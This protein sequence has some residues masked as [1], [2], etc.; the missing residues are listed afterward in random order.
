MTKSF[1]FLARQPRTEIAKFCSEER[2]D[3]G[4]ARLMPLLHLFDKFIVS[5]QVTFFLL[6]ALVTSC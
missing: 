6:V 5:H 2:V 4:I 1:L 3:D